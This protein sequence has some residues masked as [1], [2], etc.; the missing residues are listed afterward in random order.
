MKDRYRLF[1]NTVLSVHEFS[2]FYR[3]KIPLKS[4]FFR[5]EGKNNLLIVYTLLKLETS[6]TFERIYGRV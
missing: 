1:S 5:S 2:A 3:S 4:S 6:A